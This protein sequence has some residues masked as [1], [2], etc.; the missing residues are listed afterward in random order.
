VYYLKWPKVLFYK[1]I[2]ASDAQGEEELQ[3]DVLAR[4]A[5]QKV[6]ITGRLAIS[7]GNVAR[8][9][10]RDILHLVVW[11]DRAQHKRFLD[12]GAQSAK[13]DDVERDNTLRPF[14]HDGYKV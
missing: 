11:P 4:A 5:A 3:G 12:D 9:S 10:G 13:A 7:V 1:C 8:P 14:D 6:Y 2:R